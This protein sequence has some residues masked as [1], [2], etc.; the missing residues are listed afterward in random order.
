MYPGMTGMTLFLNPIWKVQADLVGFTELAASR[1]PDEVDL[2]FR[3][4]SLG[5]WV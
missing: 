5:L 3:V 1:A 2:E 4:L